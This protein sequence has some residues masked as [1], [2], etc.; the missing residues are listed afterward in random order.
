MDPIC[1][2]HSIDFISID[3]QPNAFIQALD[4]EQRAKVLAACESVA[5][6]LAL[7]RPHGS[8][9]EVIGNAK[10]AGMFAVR[11]TWP[12]IPGPQL[13]LI[14]VRDD[15]SV[16]VARGFV[17]CDACIPAS[18]VELAELAVTRARRASHER[19]TEKSDR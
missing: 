5:M 3:E 2:C 17:Q 11:V 9:T 4:S 1:T 12:G 7:G 6:S 10:L 14:C 18:E 8:R 13:R 19:E 15:N 16:L